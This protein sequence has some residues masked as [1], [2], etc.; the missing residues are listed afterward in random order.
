MFGH[1][2]IIEIGSAS[3]PIVSALTRYK[4]PVFEMELT[5]LINVSL[6]L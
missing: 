3:V 1:G 2:W 5:T 4:N 6:M